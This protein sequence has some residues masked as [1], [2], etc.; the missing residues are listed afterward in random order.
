M[1]NELTKKILAYSAKTSHDEFSPAEV[2][3]IVQRDLMEH[4]ELTQV[5]VPFV[6]FVLEDIVKALSGGLNEKERETYESLRAVVSSNAYTVRF[7]APF[8]PGEEREKR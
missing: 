2:C 8:D 7:A 6:L 1:K 5:T 4:I 3:R